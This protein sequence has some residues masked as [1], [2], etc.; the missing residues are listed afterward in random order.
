MKAIHWKEELTVEITSQGLAVLD[1]SKHSLDEFK[2]W[3]RKKYKFSLGG[4]N[5]TIFL[6]A[7]SRELEQKQKEKSNNEMISEQT[8]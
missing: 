1:Q 6:E 4:H 3:V 8:K 2:R 7:M 5:V